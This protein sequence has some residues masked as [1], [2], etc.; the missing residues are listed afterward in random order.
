LGGRACRSIGGFL[1]VRYPEKKAGV[2]ERSV[3]ADV[4]KKSRES[5]GEGTNERPTRGW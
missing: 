5:M 2:L 1:L 3:W 4:G